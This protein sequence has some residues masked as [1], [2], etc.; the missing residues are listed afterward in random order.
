MGKKVAF[1]KSKGLKELIQVISGSRYFRSKHFD[2]CFI[3]P[4]NTPS[5]SG[6]ITLPFTDVVNHSPRQTFLTLQICLLA[7]F[8]KL[9]LSL[10]SLNLQ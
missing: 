7:L 1:S 3:F 2:M 5:P 4:E 9:K 8:R 10:K 6:K